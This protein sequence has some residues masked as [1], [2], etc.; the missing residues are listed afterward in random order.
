MSRIDVNLVHDF[1]KK[2]TYENIEDDI[3]KKYKIKNLIREPE[4]DDFLYIVCDTLYYDYIG[5]LANYESYIKRGMDLRLLMELRNTAIQN[6]T[7]DEFKQFNDCN[8]PL[9]V[10]NK[11]ATAMHRFAND[12]VVEPWQL[13]VISVKTK[14]IADAYKNCDIDFRIDF[15][16]C[17]ED[18]DAEKALSKDVLIHDFACNIWQKSGAVNKTYLH[19]Y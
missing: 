1:S 13:Y 4:D 14:K 18:G 17:Y 19:K 8:T 15:E 3:V 9:E 10:V 12:D 7:D 16:D 6:L 5:G 11:R 2:K